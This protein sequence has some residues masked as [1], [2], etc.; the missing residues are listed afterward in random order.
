MPCATPYASV[1]PYCAGGP[2]AIRTAAAPYA[3][4]LER[5]D[6]DFAAPLLPGGPQ[7]ACGSGDLD[8]GE[9]SAS[10]RAAIK[11]AVS[12]IVDRGAVPI[13]LG[14]DDS[15]PIPMFSGF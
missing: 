10:N 2:E 9:D 3:A 1:G 4:N 5:M 14:G 13:V 11:T 7:D 15:I 6:F 8:Y 12:A